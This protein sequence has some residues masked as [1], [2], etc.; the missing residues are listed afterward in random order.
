MLE[1]WAANCFLE[2]EFE[3]T[4]I[5]ICGSLKKFRKFSLEHKIDLSVHWIYF[6][7]NLKLEF[8]VLFYRSWAR[9]MKAMY[10]LA[11]ISGAPLMA[12][13]WNKPTSSKFEDQPIIW[14]PKLKFLSFRFRSS[15]PVRLGFAIP[16]KLQAVWRSQAKGRQTN[17]TFD[18]VSLAWLIATPAGKRLSA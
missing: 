10:K 17:E 13:V 11:E 18:R 15:L 1:S 7:T 9:R 14:K 6:V 12:K 4:Q 5:T 3:F 2:P 16:A 8:L